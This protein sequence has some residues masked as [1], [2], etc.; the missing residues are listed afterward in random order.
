M[1]KVIIIF[2]VIML[3]FSM[4]LSLVACGDDEIDAL[5]Q[6]VKELKAQIADL[7]NSSDNS[8][9][10]DLKTQIETL[11]NTLASSIS[12]IEELE[13]DIASSNSQI[14]EVKKNIASL[15]TSIKKLETSVALISTLDNR[16]SALESGGIDAQEYA[17]LK[18]KVEALQTTLTDN[19]ASDSE[20]KSQVTEMQL[21]LDKI[22]GSD[23]SDGVL[24]EIQSSLN[25]LYGEVDRVHQFENGKEY[26][27][28]LNGVVYYT[29][30]VLVEYHDGIVQSEQDIINCTVNGLH[31]CASITVTNKMFDTLTAATFGNMMRFIFDDTYIRVSY[32]NSKQGVILPEEQTKLKHNES[33][34]WYFI[35]GDADYVATKN[36]KLSFSLNVNPSVRILI[37]DN[38]WDGVQEPIQG[39]KS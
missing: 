25:T 37:L 5:R 31:W 7:Q 32:M 36:L 6:T 34:R 22:Y 15:E 11:K 26:E 18:S 23:G 4:S 29:V 16:I 1:K 27:V 35:I 33:I 9:I 30:S 19:S 28:K 3:I 20:V 13:K 38:V 21:V 24:E 2:T 17:Q 8:N 39:V 12:H 14:E 10:E